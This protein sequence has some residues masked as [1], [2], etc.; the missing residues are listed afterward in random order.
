MSLPKLTYNDNYRGYQIWKDYER[1][2][3]CRTD[4]LDCGIDMLEWM[5]E[6]HNKVFFMRWDLH[7]PANSQYPLS[8][9]LVSKFNKKLKEY[10]AGSAKRKKIH[11]EFMWKHEQS[12]D[13]INFHVHYIA[14]FDG[15]KV[16]SIFGVLS[17]I[18]DIWL[19]VLNVPMSTKGLVEY[20]NEQYG[21]YRSNGIMIYRNA[22]DTA[23]REAVRWMSYLSKSSDAPN[24]IK[25]G[26]GWGSS[27][28]K[29]SNNV[30]V[31]LGR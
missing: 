18:T 9:D 7:F 8:N 1:N 22:E 20:C 13:C 15:N 4:M 6:E 21:G 19:D 14:V 28:F 29:K 30:N 12:P 25:H 11:I 16:Q 10:Y 23:C 27:G 24:A 31:A 17:V 26:H 2:S 3:A 5:C